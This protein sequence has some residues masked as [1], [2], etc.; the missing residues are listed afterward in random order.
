MFDGKYTMWGGEHS[1]FTRKLQAML[2]Y[3]DVDYEFKLKGGEAG[4]EMEARLGTHFIPG[5]QT[6]EGW[7]IHD[8]TPIGLM[9]NAKYPDRPIM[10]S[11]PVQ[12]IAAHLLEDWA[13]EWFG[14]YAISSRW[15]YAH[16]I[17]HVAA[18]FYGN[19]IGKFM[20]EGLTDEEQ[21]I[22]SKMIEQVR[23]NF[24]LKACANR[25]CGP[26]QAAA[27]RQDFEELMRHADAHFNQHQFLLGDRASLGDFTFAGL[28]EA[29]IAADPEPRSWIDAAAPDMVN[30]M[31]RV[32]EARSDAGEYLAD[33][34]LPDTLRPFFEHMLSNHH[35]FL[36]VSRDAL[37]LGEKWCEV[38]LGVG[39]VKMRSLKY[40]EVSRCHIR[41]EI[42]S[43]SAEDRAAVDAAL[44]PMG[45]LDAYLLPPI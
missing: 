14:R 27:V 32:F 1:L 35:K 39:P 20:A 34:S 9:L 25:G 31:K 36:V 29:H 44:G 28:F 42:V 13:D 18:G 38:D 11:S 19:S 12:R 7:F 45:V 8:T 15:C 4:K 24:G 2:N 41:N 5:L 17:E 10:P 21:A 22:A 3:L 6:P 33:D 40:S 16:N 23:D 43:L 37:A 26:D 30:Y